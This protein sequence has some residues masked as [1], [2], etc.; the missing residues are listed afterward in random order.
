MMENLSETYQS[1]LVMLRALLGDE[2]DEIARMANV[3]AF[4]FEYFP[5]I[6]W[7]GFYLVRENRQGGLVLKLGPFQGKVACM[8]IEKGKGVCGTAWQTLTTQVVPDT[9]AFEG[10]IAC[11][12]A[13]RS[14]IVVPII[15]CG[16]TEMFAELDVDS[17]E[18]NRFTLEDVLFLQACAK[19]AVA[20]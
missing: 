16:D 3:S 14:E 15:R 18:L 19:L 10:H 8:T 4:L 17:P 2:S 11:D 6:N 13:S 9:H 5:R 1:Q 7:V 20:E 12:A